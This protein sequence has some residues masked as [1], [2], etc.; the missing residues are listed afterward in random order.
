MPEIIYNKAKSVVD[1]VYFKETEEIEDS[2]SKYPT[3]YNDSST[4]EVTSIVTSSD[5]IEKIMLEN[6]P[7]SSIYDSER[8]IDYPLK[9]KVVSEE[10]PIPSTYD[11]EKYGAVSENNLDEVGYE[12]KIP[13]KYVDFEYSEYEIFENIKGIS[14]KAVVKEITE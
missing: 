11:K 12:Y 10:K 1:I 7:D 9:S 5:F 13:R 6:I 3:I 2:S 8:Q 4:D 14:R